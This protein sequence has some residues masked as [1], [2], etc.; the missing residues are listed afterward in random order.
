MKTRQVGEIYSSNHSEYS[1]STQ[2]CYYNGVHDLTLF[3]SRPTLKEKNDF[4]KQPV[5]LALHVE[6]SILFLLYR[7]VDTC[8]WSDVA[9][10]IHQLTDLEQAVPTDLPGSRAQLQ[11]T[12]VNADSGIVLAKRILHIGPAMTQALRHT[13]QEQSQ[14][15]CSRFEYK[16]QVQQIYKRYPDS[17]A[18]LKEAWMV[19]PLLNSNENLL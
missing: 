18:M 7:I 8:E 5:E 15:P 2:Y 4:L 19:E 12:L 1:E 6:Q 13:L 3:W 10:N 9:Y 17:D 11:L 14:I 16:E